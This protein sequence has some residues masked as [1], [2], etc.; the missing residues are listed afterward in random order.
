M[1]FVSRVTVVV[2]DYDAAIGFFVDALG[3][4]LIEDTASYTNDGRKK[5]WV[6]VRPPGGETGILLARADGATQAAV[7]GRQ[8][9]ERVGFFLQVD[10]FDATYAR[11]KAANVE[12]LGA[13]APSPTAASSCS[14]TSPGTAGTSSARDRSRRR[15][16]TAG[17]LRT[18]NMDTGSGVCMRRTLVLVLVSGAL[19]ACSS[20]KSTTA[21]SSS[22]QP[23]TS[24]SRDSPWAGR[25][26]P[27]MFAAVLDDTGLK[28]PPGPTPA[29]IY[30][31]S[32]TDRRT[33]R[34]PGHQW[35]EF[36]PSGPEIV[37]A[38][39]P[40]GASDDVTFRQNLIVEV[41]NDG[42]V[43]RDI[44]IDNQLNVTPTRGY[45]TPVT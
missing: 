28:L 18:S 8:T 7:V 12:F 23:T 25:A 16:G 2:D 35:L 22:S 31:V 39:I 1:S 24:S 32:F 37:L 5:R 33:R 19:S 17:V 9:S 10:D 29:G 38:T 40:A 44:P 6:V 14:A 27:P 26:S 15:P 11:M 13:P 20:S 41:A 42:V 45:S 30:R 4:E 3:F 43:E 36:R 21:G 34:G